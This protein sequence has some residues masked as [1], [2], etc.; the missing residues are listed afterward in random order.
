MDGRKRAKIDAGDYGFAE[1]AEIAAGIREQTARRR[2][3][4]REKRPENCGFW[5]TSDR[6]E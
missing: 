6:L 1:N 2:G 3:K 4:N 5:Y